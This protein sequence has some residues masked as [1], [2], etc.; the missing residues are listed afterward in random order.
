MPL[1]QPGARILGAVD[2]VAEA[3]QALAAVEH[4]VD[5]VLDARRPRR[6]RRASA[7][8]ARA[9]RRAAGR[10]AR[11]RPT[12]GR[13]RSRRRSTRTMRAVNVEALRPCSAVQIQYVSSA[14]TCRGSASP[15]HSSRKRSAVVSPCSTV[16]RGDRRRLAVRD[17]SGLRGDRDHRRRHA[18]Q[19]LLRLLVRDVDELLELPVA[20]EPGGLRLQ[21]GRA[22]A[23]QI[24]ARRKR[25]RR[26]Q[27]GL[28]RLVDEQAPDLLERHVADELLD[29]DAAVAKRAALAVRLG[30]LRLDRD[31]ALRGPA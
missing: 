22:V 15:R 10:T 30:D 2:A 7:A 11:R 9:R 14:C 31:D 5:V 18:P 29:V 23:G 4:A 21:V 17:A 13:S 26:R 24:P 1:E 6:P 16:S 19:I 27:A 28:G 3:H 8:R 12:R 20:G 25:L